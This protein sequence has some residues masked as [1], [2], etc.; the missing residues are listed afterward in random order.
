MLLLAVL[1]F[2]EPM[3]AARAL[4]FAFIWAALLVFSV[5]SVRAYRRN[6]G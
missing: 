6:R 5:D 4:S 2:D 1:V 3:G